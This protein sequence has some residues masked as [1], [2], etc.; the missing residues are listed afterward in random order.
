MPIL[1][2]M[3]WPNKH[4]VRSW[5]SLMLGSGCSS[6]R[7]LKY[8]LNPAFFHK[9]S[10]LTHHMI[11]IFPK[12][13]KG[14]GRKVLM[15]YTFKNISKVLLPFFF[16]HFIFLCSVH[17]VHGYFSLNTKPPNLSVCFW[18]LSYSF[19]YL[20]FYLIYLFIYLS[21]FLVF[22]L[23][24]FLSFFLSV[25]LSLFPSFLFFRS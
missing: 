23:P 18:Q 19:I 13:K 20:F 10:P 3:K 4:F 24:C 1:F 17:C 14:G 12:E 22:F 9:C 7:T 16:N 25:F 11:I 8:M 2:K 15:C 5:Y 6:T 21:A